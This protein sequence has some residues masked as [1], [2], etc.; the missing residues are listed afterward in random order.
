MRGLLEPVSALH[1]Y[2]FVTSLYNM[3]KL[4]LVALPLLKVPLKKY[5][6]QPT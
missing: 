2:I 1:S 4:V 6:S 3:C 5:L